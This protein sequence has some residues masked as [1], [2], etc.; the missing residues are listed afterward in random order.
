MKAVFMFIAPENDHELH[1]STITTPIVELT[2][3]GVKKYSE[4]EK[5]AQELVKEGV[6]AIE[7]CAGFGNEGTAAVS[8]AINGQVPVGVV[9][10]DNHPGFDFQSGDTLFHERQ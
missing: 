1:K 10:F 9:R 6:D 2:V 7:L 8:R 5:I 4:A 3:I